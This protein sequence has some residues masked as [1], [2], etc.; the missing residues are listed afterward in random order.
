MN[1]IEVSRQQAA[2][3]HEAAVASGK[4]PCEP[5]SF[6]CAEATRRHLAV[7]KVPKG[8][9]RLHGGRALYD[10]EA[11]LIL[12]EDVGDEFTHAFLVAHEIG[13]VEC[14]GQDEFSTTENADPLRTAEAAPIGVDRVV[15][16]SRRERQEVQM[17][18]FAREFL[19]PRDWMRCL[20]LTDGESA[21][22]ISAKCKAPVAVVS[23]QLFDALLLPSIPIVDPKPDAP[24]PLHPDQVEAVKHRG[25]P[26]L[27]E[28]GPGTGKTQTL[29]GRINDLLAGGIQPSRM[30]VLT[31]S[32]KAAGELSERIS[33]H[34]SEAAAS[35]WIGTFHAFG[36]DLIRRF[37]DRLGLSI[38]PRLIDRTEAIDLLENEYPRLE[39]VHFKNLWDPSQPLGLILNAISRANDEVVSAAQ[40]REL[41]EA[42]LESASTAEEISAAQRSLEVATVFA[43]YERMKLASGCVDFGDLVSMPVRLC[44]ASSDVRDH[45]IGTYEHVLVDEFQDVNRSSIRLL[46]AITRDGENLWAVG[47]AK[48]SIYRFRGASSFNM[49][50]FGDDDFP[51]G[52]RGRL[53]VN[54]RSVAEL[55]DMFLAFASGMCV[56][57]GAAVALEAERGLSGHLPEQRTVGTDEQEIAAVAE[58]IEEMRIAGHG[59]RKQAILCSGNERLARFARGLEQ[60]GIPVLFLGSLFERDEIKD[61]LCL[62]SVAVDRRAM[63]LLRIAAMP[64]HSV[65]L[66]DVDCVLSHL[67]D[68]VTEPLQWTKNIQAI[69]GLTA[70]GHEGLG[71]I[72]KLLDGFDA[73]ANPW[74][75]LATVLLD[76]S[77]IAAE[78]ATGTDIRA[79]A[80][81]VAIWQ[82]MNFLRN[83]PAG[84][85]LPIVR[86]L[87]RIRRLVLHADERD[88]RQLP[89][90]AQ[91]ID[92][93]RLMTMHGSKGLEFEVVHIP[94]LTAASLPRSPNSLLARGITPPNGMI[95]GAAGSGLDALREAMIEEQEC[96]FFVALSR[97]RDRLFLY[98]P[99]TTANGR[100]RPRSP[101]LDR[102]GNTVLSR[103]VVPTVTLPQ[104]D[105]D[106]PVPI[107]IEGSFTFS[108]HQL[109]LHE[110]CPRRFLY[111]HILDVGGRRTES[112]FMKLH[113]AVQ[114][115]IDGLSQNVT[116]PLP[117]TEIEDRLTAAWDIHGPVDH[118]YSDEYKRIAWQ[119]IQFYV[120]SG[121]AMQRVP[122][123]QLRVPVA[124]GEIVITPDQVLS[125][126]VGKIHIRRV[127]TGHKGSQEDDSISAAAFHIAA[128]A[129]FP[130]CTVQLVHLSDGAVTAVEM[131]S[132]VL[133]NRK[134]S[135]SKMLASVKAGYFPLEESIT[136][137]RCPAYFVCGSVPP[138]KLV[139]KLPN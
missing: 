115:V 39:L 73:T 6:A 80:R 29:V 65:S 47:D 112:A 55:R 25:K 68:Q 4:T 31:F 136:C 117:I 24:K 64:Q 127:K 34:H 74:T 7:E 14:G 75:L 15:D 30:L 60:L 128:N 76:R 54:Y 104:P 120:E 86:V 61:L 66:S 22:D 28:A 95:E 111:T 21:S 40:Y 93:V 26:F 123:P 137:P 79:R 134:E 37:H 58:S 20:H 32:N 36:L 122:S 135:I 110:R 99:T 126:A 100:S 1:S 77:R 71:R 41:S 50:R 67:K 78:I 133:T 116:H 129:H 48:Q 87:E 69:Q 84:K 83:Q 121:S 8:D 107:T 119:L 11:L 2:R 52:K 130:G 132:R 17:D 92:A 56:V 23:Q 16:Y 89:A 33:L 103:R 51:G 35:M 88:L 124:G 94:G 109:A 114:Q 108:D 113:V 102:L 3:L 118:G 12:H 81:G 97:A 138:G 9:V 18:L 10:P 42:M 70:A 98:H 27:L 82:F 72:G 91:S 43:A 57:N 38:E 59:Y 131:T 5:Y 49:K 45:L 44:E 53:K 13:H 46:K 106:M 19:L 63:G 101:F 85:G 90:A 62:L 105:G 96:L 139:K 125:D